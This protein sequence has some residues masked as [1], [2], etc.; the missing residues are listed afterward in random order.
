MFANFSEAIATAACLHPPTRCHRISVP[1]PDQVSME[2]LS[3]MEL[4][5]ESCGLGA[6][7]T[8]SRTAAPAAFRRR[9]PPRPSY[10]GRHFSINKVTGYYSISLKAAPCDS[11]KLKFFLLLR[12]QVITMQ[13]TLGPTSQTRNGWHEHRRNHPQLP[14]PKRHV[15]G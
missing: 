12:R 8:D 5:L 6:I 1:R 15:S 14:P 10:L 9:A 7:V 2:G 4:L 13:S 11:R 3:Y